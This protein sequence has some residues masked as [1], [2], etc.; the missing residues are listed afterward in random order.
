MK[1]GILGGGQLG[2]MFLQ[3]ALNYPVEIHILDPVENAPCSK[4][5][6]RFVQGDFNDYETVMNF[7]KEV[8]IIGIE[9]EHVNTEALRELQK[10]GKTVIPDPKVLDIIQDKGKQKQFYLDNNI[11]TAPIKDANDFPLIQK[12]CRG[13]YDGKGVQLLTQENHENKWKEP[14]VFET[15]ADIDLELAVIVAMN[16]KNEKAIYPVIEQVFNPKYNLLD[17]LITPARIG[18]DVKEKAKNIALNLVDTFGKPGIYAVELFLNRNGEIWVNEVA[19]RVHNSGHSTIESVYSS[20][21]DMMLRVLMNWHLGS[22]KLKC[23][24]GMLNLIG[25]PNHEGK[26]KIDGLENS[27]NIS[28]FNLHWYGKEITKPGRKMGH[29]TFI[30]DDFEQIVSDIEKVKKE[31]K[32]ISQ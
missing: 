29:I 23:K 12:L 7:A 26:S 9:I 31:I 4:I 28:G 14:S 8:D 5:A 15:L 19:P 18:E 22:T 11:P 30:G 2:R 3:N 10:Q 27:L 16:A 6:H 32:I 1:I 21:F 13:G 24:S 25:E 17:Y 20:Q